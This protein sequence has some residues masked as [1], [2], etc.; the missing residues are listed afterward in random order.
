MN[1]NDLLD[2]AF[3]EA[4]APGPSAPARNGAVSGRGLEIRTLSEV[5]PEI[6][7][8]LWRGRIPRAKVTLLVGDPGSG[9]SFAS[10]DLAAAVTTGRPLPDDPGERE[11]GSVVMWN[12]EDGI[13]DTLRPRAEQCGADLSRIKVIEGSRNDAGD[14][15]PFRLGDLKLVD[16][17]LTL[18][19]EVE[20][21]IIDPIAALLADVDAH[22]D[23]EV[24]SALQPLAE[25]AER[26]RV[27][28][29]VVMHLRKSEAQRAIYRVGGSIGFV[30]LARSV[31]LVAKDE[32]TGRRAIV[33]IKQ[34]LCAEVPPV[35]FRI[36]GQGFSWCGAADDLSAD[37]LLSTPRPV[38][39]RSALSEAEDKILE[40]LSEGP[41]PAKELE[42][43]LRLADVTRTTMNRARAHLN[44]R[45]KIRRSGGGVAGPVIWSLAAI[46]TQEIHSHSADI[47]EGEC[48]PMS[49]NER[50]PDYVESPS[51]HRQAKS[52]TGGSVCDGLLE[53][54]Y[55]HQ[56]CAF[57]CGAPGEDC[58]RCGASWAAHSGAKA[59]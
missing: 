28:V 40:K 56:D 47:R 42:R 7:Q 35:E 54:A 13:A 9:K 16:E 18:H 25:L 32:E 29:V 14:T 52:P 38:E 19:P 45:G 11:P 57:H 31:L 20:M 48:P 58:R 23:T 46:L 39:E 55:E 15:V 21:V 2:R 49:E 10:L 59:L 27:A 12:G 5:E 51:G 50:S 43:H 3:A 22:K 44:S 24:R 17:W 34:N 8:W 1:G 30:G 26:H 36:D 37:R 6:V 33:P 41:S 53:D 4:Q